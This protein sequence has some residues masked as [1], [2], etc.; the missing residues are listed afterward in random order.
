MKT[1]R[2]VVLISGR[3]SNLAALL[4]QQGLYEIVGVISNKASAAGL[5]LASGAGIDT[6][7]VDHRK[8][9]QRQD[10]D[11][12]LAESL[13]KF[14]PDLIVLAGFMRIL[15]KEFVDRFTGRMINIHPSLLPAFRGLKT[16]E[17]ALQ[18]GVL[19]HGA[20][21]HFVSAELDGGPLIAQIAFPL[22]SDDTPQSLAEKLLPMEHQLLC[23]V[24]QWCSE[25]RI[26]Y[27]QGNTYFDGKPLPCPLRLE[28]DGPDRGADGDAAASGVC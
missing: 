8:F 13:F 1:L 11:Q 22:S 18:S 19:E 23:Q 2:V 14:E 21:V 7:I 25:G 16:H 3:G 20:T 26:R 24:V 27:E 12:T 28:P 15:G 10:F 4:D 17:R 9:P 5:K 6:A